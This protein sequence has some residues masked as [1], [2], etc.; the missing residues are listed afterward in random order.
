MNSQITKE[1]QQEHVLPLPSNRQL[2]Y[3]DNG[4]RSSRIIVLFFSG[5]LSVGNAN[6]IPTPLRE[7]D[8]HYIAPTLPSNAESSTIV[9]VPY[10]VGMGHDITALLDHTHPDGIDKLYLAGGSYG[11]VAAQMLYGASYTAFPYGP[12]IAGLLIA[13]GFSPFKHHIGY[14]KT[15]TWPE[16]VV[17][18]AA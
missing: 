17:R 12:K 2:L 18:R 9:G 3:A 10:N 15:M 4:N 7:L 8:I 1:S 6:N 11:T 13:A 14:N 16:L 5:Y